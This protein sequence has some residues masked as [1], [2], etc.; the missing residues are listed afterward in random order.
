MQG[1]ID[2]YRVEMPFAIGLTVGNCT[3]RW[4]PVVFVEEFSQDL[5][6]LSGS[7]D[8]LQGVTVFKLPYPE[9]EDVISLSS[10][11]E[12]LDERRRNRAS[13]NPLSL[14]LEVLPVGERE[15]LSILSS[16]NSR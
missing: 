14:Q 4:R 15:S 7:G 9:K 16:D 10:F 2:G 3:A 5:A 12:P 1:S 6:H 13:L 8:V 11:L